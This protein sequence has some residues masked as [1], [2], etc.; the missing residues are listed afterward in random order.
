[1]S[2][3]VVQPV[4]VRVSAR[5]TVGVDAAV[6]A[7]HHVCVRTVHADGRVEVSRLHVAPSVAGLGVLSQRLAGTPGAVVI[8]EPTSMTW[9]GLSVAA[10]RAGCEFTL[11]GARHASRLRSA[12]IG[13]NKS[14]VIDADVIARAADVFDL[15]A[16]HVPSPTELA[17][18][19][20]VTRRQ[21]A[22]VDA[23]R[24]YR[25]LLSLARWAFPDVWTAFAGSLPS[26]LAVLERWPDIRGLAVARRSSLTAVVAEHTRGARDVP[27]RVEGIRRAAGDWVSFWDGRLD[28][29]ALAW[30]VGEHLR[31]YA[32]AQARVARA[33]D[34]ATRQWEAL[35][36]ADPL[37][38]SVPGMGPI[39]APIVRAYLGDGSRFASGKKAACY[40]GITPS[41]WASGTV[42]Q[43]RRAITKEGPAAL[44][45]AFYQAA[46]GA[47]RTD[48]QLAEFYHRLMTQRGQCH[49]QATI[50][51][52]RKLVERTWLVLT[53]G[54]PYELR[55][56]DGKPITERAAKVL[57]AEQLAVD[58]ETR[59]RARAHSAA[60][61]RGKLTR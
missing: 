18:R 52:A 21:N 49:T 38:L 7:N 58:P 32:E 13:K 59:A 10:E 53:T 12:I 27:T 14:D 5:V 28:L 9:L 40:V 37:L 2:V 45:L 19:R 46:N 17:L 60:T 36:G 39:T 34:A 57:I 25:R 31:D 56:L 51:V 47:R 33:T 35:Y 26:A 30:E 3:A 22:V 15:T 29:D 54:R 20:A 55:D 41:S 50:A 8:A 42:T 44:R 11:I 43:P 16:F 6:T 61:H 4:P 1:M 24:A 23:N 48:P